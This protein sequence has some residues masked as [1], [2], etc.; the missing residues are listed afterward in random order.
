M[1]EAVNAVIAGKFGPGGLYNDT[2]PS[3]ASTRANSARAISAEA[4]EYDA[5]VIACARDI[6]EYLHETHGRFPAHIDAIHVPGIWLQAHHVEIAY[7]ERFFRDGATEA[8][9]SPDAVARVAGEGN[10]L[11]RVYEAIVQGTGRGRCRR[12]LRRSGGKR[13]GLDAGAQ[14]FRAAFGRSSP[15]TNRPHPSWLAATPCIQAASVFVSRRPAQA[16]SICSQDW[17]SPCRI[18]IRC[19]RSRA[20]PRSTGKAR[21][22]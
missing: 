18:P 15:G 20:S 22:R 3:R 4:A 8:H 13:S 21:A 10:N 9:R 12:R 1:A 16:H 11:M 7:Y 5:D 14:A 17:R 6:C 2:R 19:W